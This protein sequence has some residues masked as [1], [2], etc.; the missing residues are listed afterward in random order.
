[1]KLVALVV[2]VLSLC[3]YSFAGEYPFSV[4]RIRLDGGEGVLAV[5]DGP[6]TVTATVDLGQR[7]NVSTDHSWP[8]Q[9]EL[10]PYSRISLG[11]VYPTNPS[12][13]YV[14]DLQ[15][16]KTI[17]PGKVDASRR[18]DGKPASHKE[19]QEE[20]R[21]ELQ[22]MLEPVS[23]LPR[24]FDTAKISSP[25]MRDALPFFLVAY[26]ALLTVMFDLRSF[27]ALI[28]RNWLQVIGYGCLAASTGFLLWAQYKAVPTLYLPRFMKY[29]VREP[30]S[31][32][33][34]ILALVI[35]WLTAQWLSPP[36]S[37]YN[38][39]RI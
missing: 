5:N 13:P 18:T 8:A 11:I 20:V 28:Q 30:T 6:L 19:S 16:I 15:I 1:M 7:I 26:L 27:T 33:P 39:S 17:S 14:F 37:S 35:C 36:R 2:F 10:K 21:F 38:Y 4:E 29:V 34:C 32:I 25:F 12:E 23:S 31:I 3:S 9:F 24:W 22:K